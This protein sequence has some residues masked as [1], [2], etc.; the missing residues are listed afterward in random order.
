M[1][2]HRVLRRI[3]TWSVL[4]FFREIHVVGEENVPEDGPVIVVST[5]HNMMIDPAVLSSTFPH[6]RPLHYWS[7]ASLFKHPIANRIMRNTGN[8]PVDRENKDNQVLFKGT[9]DALAKGAVVA[10]FPEG[11][12]YTEPRI[13]QVKDGA[14]WSA[15]EFTK[16]ASSN[17]THSKPLII[18]PTGIVYTN[19]AKYRSRVILSFGKPIQMEEYVVDFLAGSEKNAVKRLTARIEKEM[20]MLTINAPDWET[21]YPARMARDML[22]PGERSIDPEHYVEISQ[23]MIDLF[24]TPDPALHDVKNKL[25]TYHSLLRATNLTNSTLSG[26]PLPDA[27]NP[28]ANTSLPSRL[29][30]LLVLLRDSLASLIRLPFFI[31]PLLVHLPAYFIARV[32]AK[33]V[34]DQEETQAQNKV[35]FALLLLSVVYPAVFFFLWK[36]FWMTPTGAV[37]ALM[38]SY[39]FIVYHVK[40]I[41]SNYE[42]AKRLVAAWRVLVGVWAPTKW[43][44]SFS[45][46]APYTTPYI[47]PANSWI[48]KP[49]TEHSPPLTPTSDPSPTSRRRDIPTRRLIRHV[50]RARSN[51]ARCL[52]KFFADL[53]KNGGK[54][55]A[56]SHLAQQYGESVRENGKDVEE[57]EDGVV[58]PQ[59]PRSWRD[60]REVISFLRARGARIGE[61]KHRVEGDWAAVNSEG[62]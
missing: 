54:V 10:L 6:K 7:K 38:T 5:H 11:T 32:G 2:L 59:E 22:W 1:L 35:V 31:F 3:A 4:S 23:T 24:C 30:T 36:F 52:L 48:D 16:W 47:P 60:A 56:S 45:A 58:A 20:I 40:I 50:L 46:L 37:I 14:S 12:S 55:R 42:H 15:L 27:L 21:L 49:K 29:T 33:L 62:E 51:A 8:I 18:I 61:L 43:D 25:L 17:E 19:K 57:T 44:L 34:E 26:L 53:E 41:D 28:S 9:F 13:R 39:A